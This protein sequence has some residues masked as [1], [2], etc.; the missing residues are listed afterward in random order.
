MNFFPALVIILSLAITASSI[1]EVSLMSA[2]AA[3]ASDG[4]IESSI[5]SSLLN[6]YS[7]SFKTSGMFSLVSG[8]FLNFIVPALTPPTKAPP[9]TPPKAVEAPMLPKSRSSLIPKLISISCKK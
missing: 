2:L 3:L 9:I 5:T 6:L 1:S 7:F 4:S 8:A